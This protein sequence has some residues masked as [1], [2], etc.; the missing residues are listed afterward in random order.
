MS[1]TVAIAIPEPKS[2]RR[3]QSRDCCCQM[4]AWCPNS[5]VIPQNPGIDQAGKI[6]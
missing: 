5:K 6:C 1:K 3:T 2:H 4:I